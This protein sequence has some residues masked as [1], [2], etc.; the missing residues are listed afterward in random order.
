MLFFCNFIR[1]HASSRSNGDA[2]SWT[3]KACLE[4]IAFVLL[5]LVLII[6]F[7]IAALVMLYLSAAGDTKSVGNYK[8]GGPAGPGSG[9][10]DS[11]SSPRQNSVEDGV[12][13]VRIKTT[14]EKVSRGDEPPG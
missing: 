14:E 12:D 3:S 13:I 10:M 1:L 5:T 8:L 4:R 9:G 11:Q 2:L 6:V 7:M